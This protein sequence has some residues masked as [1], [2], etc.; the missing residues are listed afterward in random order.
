M[1]DEDTTFQILQSHGRFKDCL[2][3]ADKLGKYETLILNYI[4]EKDYAK[5]IDRI[6]AY[7][8][9]LDKNL[10]LGEG[11]KDA[12]HTKIEKF[13]D[14]ILDHSKTLILQNPLGY[15]SILGLLLER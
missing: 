6:V 11:D 1:L 8:E 2:T 12:I 15:I 9:E 14:F 4:N 7:I 13:I 3:F 5:A 10:K